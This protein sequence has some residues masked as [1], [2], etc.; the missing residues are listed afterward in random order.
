MKKVLVEAS[1]ICD[2]ERGAVFLQ[3]LLQ[4]VFS[5]VLQDRLDSEMY[6]I[7]KGNSK[8]SHWIHETFLNRVMMTLCRPGNGDLFMN[9]RE[10]PLLAIELRELS[11]R[12]VNLRFEILGRKL[13]LVL[14]E[15]NLVEMIFYEH[16]VQE[17]DVRIQ[18][19]LRRE[20]AAALK[21]GQN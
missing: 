20:L 8:S 14:T 11:F 10:Y 5:N 3:S 2:G 13:T 19:V 6:K 9:V 1:K 17:P 16:S 21:E 7:H 12:P 15:G 4:R 18:E